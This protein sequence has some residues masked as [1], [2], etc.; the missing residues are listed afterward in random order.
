MRLLRWAIFRLILVPLMRHNY[1]QRRAGLLPDEWYWAD[2]LAISWGYY[3][4]GDTPGSL[5]QEERLSAARHKRV[6]TALQ[7]KLGHE[8]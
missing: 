5:H 2:R 4:D 1:A 8:S 7:E 3:L 6:I